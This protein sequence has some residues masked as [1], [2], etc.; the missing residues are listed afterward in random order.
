M[1]VSTSSMYRTLLGYL[2]Q[3]PRAMDGGECRYH[4]HV[5]RATT[6][7]LLLEKG[8]DIRKVQDLLG[9]RNVTTTQVYDK[10]RIATKESASHG[11]PI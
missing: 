6:A 10:R 5:L 4:P 9:H 7:T 2:S 11:V 8:E 3:L 1:A